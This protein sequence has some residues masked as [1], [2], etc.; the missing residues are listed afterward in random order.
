[1]AA[2][3]KK[4]SKQIEYLEGTVAFAAAQLKEEKT[5]Y[6]KQI[7]H[8]EAKVAFVA[9]QLEAEKTKHKNLKKECSRL[10]TENEDLRHLE[11][12]CSKLTAENK[13]LRMYKEKSSS[14]HK[15]AQIREL[16]DDYNKLN[17]EYA[18]YRKK[19]NREVESLH[20]SANYIASQLQKERQP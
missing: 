1:L 9:A 8:L 20:A 5:K 7:E 12:E 18:N 16:V 3:K 6:N 14:T 13:E 10:T 17:R 15:D 19:H 2:E 4:L 11:Q